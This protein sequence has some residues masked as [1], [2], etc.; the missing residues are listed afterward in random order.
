KSRPEDFTAPGEA[1]DDLYDYAYLPARRA[2]RP[3]ADDPSTWT[4]SDDW[5]DEVPVT[6][7]EIEVFEAWFGDMFDE[8]FSTRH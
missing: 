8:W 4:V 6:E 2:G 7:A 3:I 1:P 5:P